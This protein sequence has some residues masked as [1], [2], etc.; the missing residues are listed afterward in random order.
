MSWPGIMPN[1][2]C[3]TIDWPLGARTMNCPP[4]MTPAGTVTAITVLIF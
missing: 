2:T 1:G 4:G 3:A